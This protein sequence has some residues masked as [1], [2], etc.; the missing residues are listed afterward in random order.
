MSDQK[1]SN[2]SADTSPINSDLLVTVDVTAV[3]TKKITWTSI[4]AFLKTY[5]D[6]LYPSGSGTSTGTNTGDQTDATLTTTDVTTNNVSTSKHGF[7]PKAPNDATKFLRGD[8]T[9]AVPAG[10]T[11]KAITATRAG[12]TASGT[13]NIAHG[14]GTTPKLVRI[15]AHK[16][17]GGATVA[18]SDFIYDG[19]TESGI[20]WVI[21]GA[22]SGDVTSTHMI[23]AD[24]TANS[25][26]QTAVI[27]FDATNIILTWTKTSTPSNDVITLSIIAVG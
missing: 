14:L 1:I 2:L 5:F 7:A 11:Y 24:D 16:S 20:S 25:K 19:T 8:A 21:V 10:L 12:D 18:Q 6:T 3:Q 4:K 23:I 9:W 26:N 22:A 15:L 17:V 13:Q 27:T